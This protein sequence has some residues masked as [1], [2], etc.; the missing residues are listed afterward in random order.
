V[1]VELCAWALY[2]R[3]RA[4]PAPKDISIQVP[5]VLAHFG[6]GCLKS[7]AAKPWTHN[8][9]KSR[10]SWLLAAVGW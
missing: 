7:V 6:A 2:Q 4:H 8:I 3:I 10:V 9:Q 1:G 5:A